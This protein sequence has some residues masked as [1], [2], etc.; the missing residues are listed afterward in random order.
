MDGEDDKEKEMDDEE[1]KKQNGEGEENET[2]TEDVDQTKKEKKKMVDGLSEYERNRA[3]NIAQLKVVMDNLKEKYPFPEDLLPKPESK[4]SA[5]K[6]KQKQQPIERRAST[7]NKGG[8]NERYVY[9]RDV[10]HVTG[11]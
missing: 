8:D 3:K 5:A 9:D 4:K 7:R 1:W 6:K 11:L 10:T 2:D